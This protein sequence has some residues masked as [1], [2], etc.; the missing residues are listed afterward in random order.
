MDHAGAYQDSDFVNLRK[1]WK[2][3]S[4]VQ[5]AAKIHLDF[6]MECG[7]QH[8]TPKGLRLNTRCAA[9]AAGRTDVSAKFKHIIT[10]AQDGLRE[11][12]IHHYIAVLESSADDLRKTE[13]DLE[14]AATRTSPATLA[15]HTKVLNATKRNLVRR[16][17]ARRQTTNN[18]LDKLCMDTNGHR[19]RRED[20]IAIEDNDPVID[21]VSADVGMDHTLDIVTGSS[22]NAHIASIQDTPTTQETS[23]TSAHVRQDAVH[24]TQRSTRTTRR[25]VHTT[26]RVSQDT[27]HTSQEATRT[28][29]AAARTTPAAA[30]TTPAAARTTPGAAHTTPAATRLAQTTPKAAQTTQAARR[31][32]HSVGQVPEASHASQKA[33]GRR[34]QTSPHRRVGAVLEATVVAVGDRKQGPAS[35][36]I[37]RGDTHIRSTGLTKAPQRSTQVQRSEDISTSPTSGTTYQRDRDVTNSQVRPDYATITKT[38]IRSLL[39]S[40]SALPSRQAAT[41]APILANRG[42]RAVVVSRSKKVCAQTPPTTP[43]DQATCSVDTPGTGNASSKPSHRPTGG[44][45]SSKD[46]TAVGVTPDSGIS[47]LVPTESSPTRLTLLRRQ[48]QPSRTRTTQ[49]RQP[50]LDEPVTP[51]PTVGTSHQQAQP[52][53]RRAAQQKTLFSYGT[54]VPWQGTVLRSRIPVRRDSHSS[55]KPSPTPNQDFHN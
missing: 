21:V 5:G 43:M 25:T 1:Q 3:R 36:K 30:H 42:E 29:P 2:R 40:P 24:R 10:H 46:T 14:A 35:A 13:A 4:H 22:L 48:P 23:H 47:S 6:L 27:A 41:L 50:I 9:L 15:R 19:R 11:A 44:T 16:M 54:K 12:L 37:T 32:Q 17:K 51:A 31:V 33:H 34:K 26:Q 28:T 7:R 52:S 38:P 18:K 49:P 8:I 45:Q 55:R 39:P 20:I 53:E